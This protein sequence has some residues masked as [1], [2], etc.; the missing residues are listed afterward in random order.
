MRPSTLIPLAA[1]AF[2]IAFPLLSENRYHQYVLVTAFIFAI[3]ASGLNV[4]LGFTGL[5]NLAHAA[6]FGIGAYA[7]GILMLN[8]GW[9]FWLALPA[10]ITLTALLGYLLGL[11]AFRTRGD[12]FAIF[13]LAVGVIVTQ[14]IARWDALTGGRDGLNGIPSI[15][16]LGPI[17]FDKQIAFYYL[18]LAALVLTLY[19]IRAVIKAPVGRSFVAVRSNEDLARAS[20]IDTF[21]HK[22]RALM[23]STAIA[24]LAGGLYAVQLQSLGPVSASGTMITFTL[25][26]YVIVGG[27]ATLAGPVI[28][29]LL[30]VVLA[31][32]LQAFEQYQHLVLGPLLV[33]LVLFFPNGLMGLWSRLTA[34]RRRA[35]APA[36]APAVPTGKES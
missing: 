3:A 26:L 16:Q 9:S 22:Q 12:A 34:P 11:V 19:V 25:L 2:A 27:V 33:I 36:P 18:A 10:A 24:G 30:L 20:G 14:I 15:G 35:D 21:V 7:V 1:L 17:N 4:L 6:F 29:T 31:Q 23:L 28:G 32:L 13:T 8:L 5:L